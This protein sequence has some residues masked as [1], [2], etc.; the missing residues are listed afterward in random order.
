MMEPLTKL[1]PFIVRVKL[2]DPAA[3]EL[4]E[5]DEKLGL[6]LFTTMGASVFVQDNI[7]KKR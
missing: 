7:I 1:V 5:M 6:G 3:M 4:G 2:A